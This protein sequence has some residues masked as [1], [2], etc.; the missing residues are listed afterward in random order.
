MYSGSAV[1]NCRNHLTECLCA[2]VPDRINPVNI[3]PRRLVCYDISCLVK[4]KLMSEKLGYGTPANAYEQSVKTKL[5]LAAV[6]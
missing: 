6:L 1:G 5:T 2:N 4:G 3:G